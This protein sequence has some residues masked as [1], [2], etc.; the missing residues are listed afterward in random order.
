MP[1]R[2]ILTERQNKMLFELPEDEKTIIRFYTLSDE[3]LAIIRK[4]RRRRNQLG[5][6]LQLCAFRF[7]G[8]VLQPGELIPA[9]MLSFVASQLGFSEGELKGYAERE[10][11][12]YEHLARLQKLY[13]Y[14][15]FSRQVRKDIVEWLTTAAEHAKNNFELVVS[16]LEELRQRRIILPAASTVERLCADALVEAERRISS[17][18]TERLSIKIR[19]RLEALLKEKVDGRTSQF[20]W[21][22]QACSGANSAAMNRILDRL[23]VIK[24][25]E[26]EPDIIRDIPPHRITR[27][28]K[29]GERLYTSTLKEL[30][31][32]RRFSI[33]V[34]CIFEWRA[35]FTDVAIETHER[36]I[37]RLYNQAKRRQDEIVCQ[38]KSNVV[39]SLQ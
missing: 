20:V 33:L 32:E 22:R 12:R 6:A 3:D 8:R 31:V 37:G 17:R 26:L 9:R 30:P 36:I 24:S 34:A 4:Q 29:E 19:Y 38:E 16:F 1:R 23:G 14:H 5:F 18:I 25:I 13:A 15:P 11:T 7:P 27:L 28:R 39:R 21:L 10:E 35:I 2:T